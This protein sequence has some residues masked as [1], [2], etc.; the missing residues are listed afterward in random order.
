MVTS[1]AG[2]W[3]EGSASAMVALTSVKRVR[4]K[5]R[6]SVGSGRP[7]ADD[8][9]AALVAL[10]VLGRRVGEVVAAAQ[11]GL[12][13][14]EAGLVVGLVVAE[15]AELAADA[16][17]DRRDHLAAQLEQVAELGVE[18]GVGREEGRVA[19]E[20]DVADVGAPGEGG[21]DLGAEGEVGGARG[22][23]DR[24]VEV[25]LV[26]EALGGGVE[27]HDARGVVGEHGA[28]LLIDAQPPRAEE[29]EPADHQRHD[30]DQRREPGDEAGEAQAEAAA[31]VGRARGQV[32]GGH[33]RA[34]LYH[35]AAVTGGRPAAQMGT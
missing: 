32:G 35:R 14:V 24:D 9:Q 5:E 16:G 28:Q 23:A 30:D 34:G 22:A 1:I 4:A 7:G 17:L 29:A 8:D 10:E 6:S 33:A 18:E 19:V 25:R 2:S 27:S 26:A 21:G 3:A 20:E 13:E 15:G 12:V 31:A 11:L